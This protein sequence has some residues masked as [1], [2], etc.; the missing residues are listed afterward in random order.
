MGIRRPSRF[1]ALATV[2]QTYPAN[3]AMAS[4]IEMKSSSG[5]DKL[6]EVTEML[7]MLRAD[8]TEMN[9][10][11]QQRNEALEK[12]KVH[13]RSVENADPIFTKEGI[14]TLCRHG[15]HS[16]STT[17]SREA[18]RCLANALLLQTETRQIFVDLGFSEKV[19]E[20]LKSDNRDDEFLAS[21]I[22]FLTTYGTNLDFEKLMRD[23][24]LAETINQNIARHSKRYPKSGR[25]AS[26]IASPMEDMALSETLKLM[27]N[28]T[29]F[30]PDLAEMFSKSIAH[31][32]KILFRTRIPT[33]P[34][35]PPVCYLVNAL[36]NLDLEGKKGSQPLAVNPVFPKFDQKLNAEHLIKILDMAITQY[37]EKELDTV[38]APVLVLIR[39]VYE[40]APDT[41]KRYM[42]CLLLPTDE[43]RNMPLGQSDTLSSRLLRL[44]TCPSTPNLRESISAMFFEISGKDA[45]TFVKNVGYG[46][47]S[48]FLMSHN[49]AVPE[50]ASDAFSSQTEG[51]PI[52]P[53]TGQ[54][55]DAEAIETGPEMTEEEKEREAEKL[56]VLFERLKKT[57]VMN[58]R[59]PVEQAVQ[60]GRFEELD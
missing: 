28:I 24:Q 3:V 18:L 2:P 30:Y 50:N 48:G 7:N 20:L 52:N 47:A 51:T 19:C 58:V 43:E 11:P 16:P 59:N 42:Q 45:S 55:L 9:L 17:T 60:E 31:I 22:L 1:R 34:L 54:R 41:V 8:L 36:M 46:F 10:L 5:Q 38:A 12:L 25:R 6:Q 14:D 21:R 4:M 39:R 27:F 37:P 33:P 53:I 29:N 57:G 35:H 49:I 32:F 44:S 15:F 40:F 26:S 56:F 13:G 23:S